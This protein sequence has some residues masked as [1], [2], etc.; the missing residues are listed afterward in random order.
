MM[1]DARGRDAFDSIMLRGGV[2][3]HECAPPGGGKQDGDSSGAI[4]TS[5][6]R[7]SFSQARNA[8]S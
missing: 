2:L 7:N 5:H 1:R 3:G 4:Q 6:G 8:T